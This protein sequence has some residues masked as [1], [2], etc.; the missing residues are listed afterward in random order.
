MRD[1]L[2]PGRWHC[3]LAGIVSCNDVLALLIYCGWKC[4]YVGL[5]HTM[6]VVMT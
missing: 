4:A 5:P 6:Y 1:D 2:Q 3:A